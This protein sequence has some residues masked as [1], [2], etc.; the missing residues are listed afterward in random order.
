MGVRVAVLTLA[1]VLAVGLAIG[2]ADPASAAGRSSDEARAA[3]LLEG[4]RRKAGLPALAGCAELDAVARAWSRSMGSS[5]RLGHNPG[6]RNQIGAWSA[7]AENVGYAGSVDAVHEALMGSA[8]HRANMLSDGF[9]QVGIGVAV[10]GSRTWITQVFRRP[11]SGAPCSAAQSEPQQG[12]PDDVGRVAGSDRHETA[13]ELSRRTFSRADTAVIASSEQFPEAL[14][15]GPLADSVDGPILLTRSDHLDDATR[16]ELDRLGV[17]RAIVLGSDRTLSSAIDDDLADMGVDVQR[18]AGSDRFDTSARIATR[19]GGSTVVIAKGVDQG[20]ADAIAASGYAAHR[21]LPILL[22]DGEQLT[23]TTRRALGDMGVE[24]AEIIGG[25]AAVSTDIE[26]TLDD[27]GIDVR[28]LAG[29]DRLVTS[30][31]VADASIAAGMSPDRVWLST[32]RNWADALAAGP[33]VARDGGVL[34]LSEP[35]GMA[36]REAPTQWLQEQAGEVNDLVLIGGP[37]ALADA[38]G[39]DASA[40]ISD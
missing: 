9:T 12:L 10:A 4:S 15:A 19:V 24:R 26:R 3:E 7:W 11:K 40:V 29:A 36:P 39:H 33:A 8:G 5:G 23:E 6:V 14:I 1:V 37:A 18:I 13:A 25:P 22:V 38:V 2:V 35:D 21:G 30:A 27:G 17:A 32:A 34:L 20:W 31:R 16:G 28:R